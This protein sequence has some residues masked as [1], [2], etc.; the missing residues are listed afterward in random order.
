MALKT[1]PHCGHSVSDQATKCP[2]CGKDPRYTDSQLEQHEQQR[3]KKRKTTFIVST[4]ALMVV[5][6]VLCAIFIPRYIEYSHQMDAYNEALSFFDS[7]EYKE[8][9]LAFD[10]LEGF[11]DSKQK[12]L[13]ARYQYVYN[14]RSRTNRTTLK[15]IEYLSSE[16][17]P[18]IQTLSDAIYKWTYSAYPTNK[19]K[20]DPTTGSF[21]MYDPLYF[22]FKVHGG[23]PNEKIHVKY[24]L[25]FYVSGFAAS[26]GYFD[27]TEYGS[28]PYEMADGGHYWF[29]W[30]DG[31][32]TA[33]YSHV[34]ITF[35]NADTNT[36]LAAAE[37]Y[38][39]S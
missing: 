16:N 9:V 38:I 5:L 27:N 34:K 28:V 37:A 33:R 10:A 24:R 3:K 18:N 23:R 39:Q 7:G 20:G 11:K 36:T 2:Q 30:Q 26:L 15:Y 6:A 8:A 1:C 25:D 4:S 21:G 17:Y 19:E 13:D 31:I 12:A 29:G 22:M 14:N 35:Y 32:G